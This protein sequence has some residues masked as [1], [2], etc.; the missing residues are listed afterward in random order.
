MCTHESL[1]SLCITEF[2]RIRSLVTSTA[3][4]VRRTRDFSSKGRVDVDP[5][6][7][8]VVV[9]NYFAHLGDSLV[10]VGRRAP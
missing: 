2:W 3:L 5:E 8:C 9:Y 7:E 4:G 6:I 1:I 10:G